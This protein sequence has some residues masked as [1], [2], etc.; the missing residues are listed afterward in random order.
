MKGG[1]PFNRGGYGCIFKPALR[2]KNN[3][4]RTDGVS[5]LL[6]KRFAE[7]EFTHVQKIR[8]QLK[9][10]T[11]LGKYFLLNNITMCEPAPLTP[12]DMKGFD[13]YCHKLYED[14][15]KTLDE[16]QNY[17]INKNLSKYRIINMPELG[18][19]LNQWISEEPLTIEKL[20][21]LNNYII[22]LIQ[23]AVVPMN[24]NGVVHNDLKS[25]NILFN[26]NTPT[27]IDWGLSYVSTNQNK[28]PNEVFENAVQMQNPF[29]TFLF[30]EAAFSQLLEK[31]YDFLMMNEKFN[32]S[33]SKESLRIF[34]T[35]LYYNF[36]KVKPSQ[37]EFYYTIF[38][39][40]L[41]G[42]FKFFLKETTDDTALK[43]VDGELL[44]NYISNYITD[45][46]YH[47]TNKET[48][49]FLL[50]EYFS[51]VYIYNCDIWGLMSIFCIIITIPYTSFHIPE[52][53]YYKYIN[54]LIDILVNQIFVNGHEK[55]NISKL[56]NSIKK[57]N[58][59]VLT[60]KNNML[61]NT[62][63]EINNKKIIKKIRTTK[64]SKSIKPRFKGLK[65][66]ITL[67]RLQSKRNQQIMEKQQ[68]MGKSE[69]NSR[70]IS[71]T[72]DLI[73]ALI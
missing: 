16:I 58:D 49:K 25:E 36:S 43:L 39:I 53:I 64:K 59:G 11:F 1:L 14:D 31:Y 20:K 8:Q 61:N 6:E 18:N 70:V 17:D 52:N 73:K 46:L 4:K 27:L 42:P 19:S 30:N 66:S 34:S 57:I 15:V 9:H 29:S 56:I 63:K 50:Q 54:S 60:N 5:K 33:F 41:K 55:I 40:I 37:Y 48:K 32:T 24:K 26:K 47:F 3:N 45:I 22:E 72:K 35:T 7:M 13:E 51:K 71:N 28:M 38:K 21:Q 62:I 69:N 2:C 68:I 65:G 10:L 44:F 12:D 23:N 67:K